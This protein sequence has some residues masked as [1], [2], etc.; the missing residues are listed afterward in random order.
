VVNISQIDKSGKD[1]FEKDK[2][3]KFA[4]SYNKVIIPG[5]SSELPDVFS[6]ENFG[7]LT[8]WKK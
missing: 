5:D 1:I 2:I 4:D 8:S 6:F 3:Y 7:G